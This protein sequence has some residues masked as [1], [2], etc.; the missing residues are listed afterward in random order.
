MNLSD[1]WTPGQQPIARTSASEAVF[2]A[3]RSA[4]EAQE[5]PLGTKLGSEASLA[6]NYAVSRSVIREAL[7]SCAALGLTR[8]ETGRGTF[9]I[10]HRPTRDLVLGGH[11]SADLHEARPHIEIP[12]AELAA[13]RRTAQDLERLNGLIEEMEQEDGASTWVELDAAFHAAVA[14]ASGNSVFDRVVGDIREAMA[15]QSETV[16]LVAGRRE[17]SN[18]EHRVIVAAIAAGDPHAAA[19]AMAQHLKAVQQAVSTIVRSTE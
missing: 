7:R 17:P 5:I 6:A 3:L 12:A 19:N 15:R 16:N 4:I 11:S 8:T 9:V 18:R 1:S 2:H 13:S 10:S 14:R